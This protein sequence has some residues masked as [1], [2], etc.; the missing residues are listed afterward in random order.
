MSLAI[1]LPQRTRKQN[2]SALYERHQEIVRLKA[3]GYSNSKIAECVG[4]SERMVTLTL[5]SPLAV[6]LRQ[7]IQTRKNEDA[8]TI[9]ERIASLSDA[10]VTYMQKILSGE[11]ETAS[12]GL[13]VKVCES[14]LDRAGHSRIVKTQATNLTAHLTADEI[15][16]L[17]ERAMISAREAGVIADV[18]T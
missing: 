2:L 14:I 16:E 18:K 17:R 6:G 4:V 3:L 13:R 9:N 11:I 15:E 7:E 8:A 12:P 5:N 1:A 10:A